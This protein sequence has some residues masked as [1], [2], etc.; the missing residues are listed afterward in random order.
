[1]HF[2]LSTDGKR[3]TTCSIDVQK[4]SASY[5]LCGM[6][7][8]PAASMSLTVEL[9]PFGRGAH[10]CSAFWRWVRSHLHSLARER[11]SVVN[12]LVGDDAGKLLLVD[13]DLLVGDVTYK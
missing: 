11:L 10:R 2:L 8:N 12:L 9:T 13:D 3:I 4:S 7:S 1:M 5:G 6:A